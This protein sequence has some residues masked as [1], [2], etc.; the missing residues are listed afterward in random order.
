MKQL[1]EEL[2]C[3]QS[4]VGCLCRAGHTFSSLSLNNKKGEHYILF[5]D[6]ENSS[7]WVFSP[8]PP[9]H[10]HPPA[11][12]KHTILTHSHYPFLYCSLPPLPHVPLLFLPRLLL[13]LPSD[14]MIYI[15][16]YTHTYIYI[17]IYLWYSAGKSMRMVNMSMNIRQKLGTCTNKLQRE[18]VSWFLT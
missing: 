7:H 5:N 1:G 3:S 10:A 15:Y 13:L 12:K 18:T 8:P 17:Y 4:L 14:Y 6:Q 11:P 9:P 16:I 2:K